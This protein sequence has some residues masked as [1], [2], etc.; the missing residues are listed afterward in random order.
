M[1]FS[2][3]IQEHSTKFLTDKPVSAGGFVVYVVIILTIVALIKIIKT[4]DMVDPGGDQLAELAT[5]GYVVGS[6]G[7]DAGA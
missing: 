3:F 4:G 7:G 5:A 6:S 1:G 2:V